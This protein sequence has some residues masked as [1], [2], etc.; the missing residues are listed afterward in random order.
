[1]L[2]QSFTKA[3]LQ[4]NQLKHKQL[5]SQIDFALLQ[6]CTLK[7]VPYLIKHE[8]I[9]PHQTHDSHPILA[10][11]GTDQFSIRIDDEGNDIVVKPLHS[12]SF[13]S[14]TPFQTKFKTPIKK[15]NKTLQQQSLL[16]NDTHVTSDD[17]DHIYTR[18]PK[19]DYF[20]STDSTLQENYSTLKKSPS[21]TP[22]ETTCAINVQTNSPSLTHFS[23]V[24]PFCDTSFLKFKNYFQGFF[25]PSLTPL[26]TGTPFL[27]AQHKRFS[28]LFIDDST[29]F[30]TLYFKSSTVLTQPSTPEFVHATF[31]ICLPF[32]M[33]KTVFNKLHEHSHTGIK[34]TYKTF[35]R[36]Y[37][38][39][40]VEKW[41][42]IFIHDCIECQCN[43]HFNMKIQTAPTQSFSEHAPS[44]N[45]RISMDTKGPINPPSHNKPYINVIID[46]FSHFVVTVPIKSK[47]A[48]TVIK[49]LLHHWSI[50]FGPPIYLVTDRGSEYINKEMAHLCTLMG[51]RHSPRKAYSPCTNGLVEVQNRNLGTRLRM[52]L[53]DTPKDWA[54]QVHMYAYAH[55]SQTLSELN[56]SP[57]EIVFH[58]RPRIPLTFD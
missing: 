16:L 31:R 17:E 50:K 40:F 20:F 30:I 22:Q 5:P 51:I 48:K 24:I 35:A 41:L 32:R 28:Q 27:H 12:F 55:N 19:F 57:R 26:I 44:F 1:M 38:I 39:P 9:L 33:F 13:K 8:E 25:L 45:Y 14:V 52:F 18:I 36:Y 46:A 42:S 23:Q 2:S 15:N 29:N 37:Y 6:N 43:K 54:F 3:E 47:N 7:P 56:I 4:L 34:I 49:T 58:T 10:D 53:H 11:Y 21:N